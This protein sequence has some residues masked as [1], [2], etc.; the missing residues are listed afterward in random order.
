MAM[1]HRSTWVASTQKYNIQIQICIYTHTHAHIY[2]H[3]YIYTYE[4]IST[5]I[6]IHIR[7]PA[8]INGDTPTVNSVRQCRHYLHVLHLQCVNPLCVYVYVCVDVS[9]YLLMRARIHIGV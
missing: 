1:S 3:T 2:V 5:Y 9:V 8:G 7:K 4:Y 6:H